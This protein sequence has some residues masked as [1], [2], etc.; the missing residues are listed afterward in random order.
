MPMW[1]KSR[2]QDY[3]TKVQGR[4]ERLVPHLV[5]GAFCT[6][7]LT[8]DW[9]FAKSSDEAMPRQ[10]LQNMVN[11]ARKFY[12]PITKHLSNSFQRSNWQ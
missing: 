8:E 11:L 7:G 2:D 12:I 10:N 1:A 5:Q 4:G 3:I 9:Q 6:S